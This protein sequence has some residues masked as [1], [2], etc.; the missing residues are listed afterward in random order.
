MWTK[1]RRSGK[2]VIVHLERGITPKGNIEDYLYGTHEA[3]DSSNNFYRE[4]RIFW[5]FMDGWTVAKIPIWTWMRR[6]EM[7][8]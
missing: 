8:L 3:Y 2:T 1:P 7:W 5:E 6:S 4:S